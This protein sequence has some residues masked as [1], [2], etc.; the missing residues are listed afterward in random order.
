MT[1][2]PRKTSFKFGRNSD[3]RVTLSYYDEHH[4]DAPLFLGQVV[5]ENATQMFLVGGDLIKLGEAQS[6]FARVLDAD[7]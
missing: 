3:G 7:A 6:T 1:T 2:K 4:P 5:F